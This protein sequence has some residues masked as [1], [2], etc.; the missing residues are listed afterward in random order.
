MIRYLKQAVVGRMEVHIGDFVLVES[1]VEDKPFINRCEALF[2]LGNDSEIPSDIIFAFLR[3]CW[4]ISDLPI[5]DNHLKSREVY[6]SNDWSIKPINLILRKA[7]VLPR[8]Q[9][10]RLPP[11]SFRYGIEKFFFSKFYDSFTGEIKQMNDFEAFKREISNYSPPH[12]IEK[13]L[14]YELRNISTPE[15]TDEATDEL[16]DD[17]IDNTPHTTPTPPA[18]TPLTTTT[19]IRTPV[20]SSEPME[21]HTTESQDYEIAYR[22]SPNTYPRYQVWT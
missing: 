15:S 12:L 22:E 20:T 17:L 11:H 14:A 8:I 2:V 7:E 9:Y 16:T 5:G 10:N 21:D 4:R 6:L 19:P 13:A 1:G 3:S 18:T